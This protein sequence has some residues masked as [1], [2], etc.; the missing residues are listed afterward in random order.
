LSIYRPIIYGN[1]ATVL[2]P[3][4]RDA[5]PHPDHTHRWTVAVRS[6]ASEPDSD[7]VGGADD[8]SYFIKRVTFKLHDTYANPSRNVDKPP[9]EVSETGW[10]EFEITIRITFI[11]ESGEKAMTLYHHL[12][13]HP[14]T[15]SGDPEIPPLDVAM[16]LGPVHSWQYD[17]IVFNDP[18]QNFLNLLTAH[19]PTPLPKAK[20]RGVPEFNT[21]M[22]K[23]EADRLEE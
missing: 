17:E 8:L 23:E 20:R 9:F 4:E 12:K 11:T 13:L 3:R 21:L 15:A 1:T 2:T 10:G 16:K 18:Y 5:L 22:E 6:A 7:E 14:W 19:P